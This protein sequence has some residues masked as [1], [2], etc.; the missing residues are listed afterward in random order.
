M[1]VILMGGRAA[2]M[3]KFG[4]EGID[5]GAADDLRKARALAKRAIEDWGMGD[6]SPSP[7]ARDSSDIGWLH[8]AEQA[9]L[10]IIRDHMARLETMVSELL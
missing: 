3:V 1:L 5:A 7:G 4:E 10:E 8:A 9:A 6:L 2:Q